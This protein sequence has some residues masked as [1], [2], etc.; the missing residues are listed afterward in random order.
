METKQIEKR[1]RVRDEE[2]RQAGKERKPRTRPD[3]QKRPEPAGG[4]IKKHRERAEEAKKRRERAEEAKKR[5]E[6][7]EEAKKCRERAEEAKKHRERAAQERKSRPRPEEGNRKKLETEGVKH[8]QG[9]RHAEVTKKK[10]PQGER[11]RRTRETGPSRPQEERAKHPQKTGRAQERQV[12]QQNIEE[13]SVKAKKGKKMKR[14]KR[15]EKKRFGIVSILILL[16]AIIVFCVSGYK[17]FSIYYGYHKGDQEYDQLIKVGI[18]PNNDDNASDAEETP[19]YTVDFE[20]LWKINEDIIAW[21]RFD[22]PSIINYPVVQ[23]KDN[24]EYLDK[25]ISGYPN[26][27][28]AIFLNV[29][30]NKD[31][32]DKNSVIYG[33]RMNSESMF[34]KLEEYKEQSFYEKYPYF[35]LYTPDG[36]EIKYQIFAVGEVKDTSEAYKTTFADTSEF[37]SFVQFGKDHSFYDTKVEVPDDAQVVTLSTCTKANNEDRLIVQAYKAEEQQ[38]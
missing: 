34:G 24:Q 2:I 29:Y 8:S 14:R 36:K 22:E 33:H 3:Q 21:I 23:G 15:Q 20:E 7:A 38:N 10:R 16:L 1:R 30:N 12:S 27:Y 25:T 13:K 5:R 32:S 37:Q 31:L 9:A 28:G 6:R 35:Y 4:Q 19:K 11:P 26:T 18:K 17:L